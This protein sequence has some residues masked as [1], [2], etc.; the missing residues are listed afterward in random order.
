MMDK[1]KV[2]L[3]GASGTVGIDIFKELLSRL[4][5]YDIRL[6]L[7]ASKK[8]KKQFI[9]YS[10]RVKIIWGSIE[11]YEEV[12]KAVDDQDV[13]IHCA[14]VIPSTL[15]YNPENVNLINVEGT[16]N[17]V[18]SM[19]LQEKPTK[20]IY[21]SSI[22]VYGDRIKDPN[23]KITDPVK[24]TPGHPYAESKLAAEQIIQESGL[25]YVIF[26]LSYCTSTK[27]L[28]FRPVLFDIPLKTSVEIIDTRDVALAL[29]NS[30]ETREIWGNIFNLGG[31]KECQIEFGE[32]IDDML[33]I[34]GFGRHFFPENAFAKNDS[35]CGFYDTREIETILKF[36]KHDL[37][38]FY[39]DVKRW[40]G[41][42]RYLVPLVRPIIRWA[43]LKRSEYYK[44]NK[45]K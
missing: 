40:I 9:P 14:A 16:R 17:V 45:K 4:D 39:A 22:S 41:V 31:G 34:M 18:K 15:H 28:K 35:H 33:E 1:T 44:A 23:I 6:F 42:K 7:R 21:P 11:N 38:D 24:I 12:K 37:S 2:L 36:Q 5:I 27:M 29:V 25:E 13:V 10:N 8:N 32:H 43:L 3:T 26:R 30:I 19:L 20:I